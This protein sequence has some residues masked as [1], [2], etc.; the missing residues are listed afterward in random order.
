MAHNRYLGMERMFIKNK[1]SN[2]EDDTIIRP[3]LDARADILNV[4]N[5]IL[6]KEQMICL[7]RAS[8]KLQTAINAVYVDM[9]NIVSHLAEEVNKRW[10]CKNNNKELMRI[11]YGG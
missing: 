9:N 7:E 3:F 11:K 8:E 1:Y 4:Q 2:I 10:C 6:F 5:Q